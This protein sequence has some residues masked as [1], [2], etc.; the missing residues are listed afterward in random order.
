[1]KNI[2]GYKDSVSFED[3][4]QNNALCNVLIARDLPVL[5]SEGDENVNL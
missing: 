1:M 5:K 2:A 3:A 4:T